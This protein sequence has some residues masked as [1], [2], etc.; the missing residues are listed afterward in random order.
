[1]TTATSCTRRP[2]SRWM[3]CDC[4]PCTT[5]RLR[6]A[7]MARCGLLERIPSAQ[8]WERLDQWLAAGY[9][10]GWIASAC[11][12]PPRGLW[13]AVN[14]LRRTGHRRDFGHG[15][16]AAIVAA[17]IDTATT[18][19]RAA[20]GT[21]RRLQALAVAGWT[22]EALA[23]ETGVHFV[24]LAA[25]QRG[26][27]RRIQ[28]RLWHAITDT[29]E[30]LEYAPGASREATRRALERSWRP[31]AMWDD[32]DADPEPTERPRR[33]GRE[34][35]DMDEFDYLIAAGESEHQAAHQLGVTTAAIEQARVRAARK[36]A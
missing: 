27:S 24:T 8:A 26:Q 10:P 7:K 16:S 1:M 22:V 33:R 34:G 4:E 15:Y 36:V 14:E 3:T 30:R 17:D 19:R 21:R 29:Y 18:G 20:T 2:F 23:V 35:F 28:A 5:E 6:T 11:G 13:T 31:A 25:F 12:L 32:P 9:E